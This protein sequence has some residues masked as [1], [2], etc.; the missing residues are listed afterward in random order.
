MISMAACIEKSQVDMDVM[1][2]FEELADI[3]TTHP[4]G[5]GLY[6]RAFKARHVSRGCNVVYKSLKA[7]PLIGATNREKYN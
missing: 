5:E 6:T 3:D 1:I 4:L 7:G 2:K